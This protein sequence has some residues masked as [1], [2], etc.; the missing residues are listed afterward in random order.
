MLIKFAKEGYSM[1]EVPTTYKARKY[2]K[3]KL[4]RFKSGIEIFSTIFKGS[5]DADTIRK[6]EAAWK[7]TRAK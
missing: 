6:R 7:K 2:G 5:L 1:I 3:P 4:R